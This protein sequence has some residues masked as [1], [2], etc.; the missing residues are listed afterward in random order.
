[1][2]ERG[3]EMELIICCICSIFISIVIGNVVGIYYLQN[4]DK[5]WQRILDEVMEEIKKHMY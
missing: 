5:D 3:V 4:L 2:Q 1:M